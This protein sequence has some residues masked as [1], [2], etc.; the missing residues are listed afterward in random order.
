M[1]L[2]TSREFRIQNKKI[3][4]N[5]SQFIQ[6]FTSLKKQIVYERILVSYWSVVF[7]ERSFLLWKRQKIRFQTKMEDLSVEVYGE[8]GA[9]Y[10]VCRL[11]STLNCL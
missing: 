10:K 6:S 9:Y 1:N 5:E 8:N 2:V 11:W 4:I 3:L 7:Y